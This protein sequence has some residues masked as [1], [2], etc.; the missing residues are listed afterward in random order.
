MCPAK[1]QR[2]DFSDPIALGTT[3][4]R[5]P[6][7]KKVVLLSVS[8]VVVYAMVVYVLCMDHTVTSAADQL[9]YLLL[10]FNS[11]FS[12]SFT[13][14]VYGV[15]CMSDEAINV[16][17]VFMYLGLPWLVDQPLWFFLVMSAFFV[18]ALFKYVNWLTRVSANYFLRR[19]IVAN[20][21]GA[22]LG[23][24]AAM[25]ILYWDRPMIIAVVTTAVFAVANVQTLLLDPLYRHEPP[26]HP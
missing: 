14:S 9:F 22:M 3:S 2:H 18:I 7:S 26:A 5:T 4:I 23:L 12:V 15:R 8:T 11:Y 24:A 1:R 6:H 21:L 16:P 19:K 17:L 10:M 25:A 13:E 20:G